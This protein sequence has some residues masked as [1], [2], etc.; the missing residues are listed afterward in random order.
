MDVLETVNSLGHASAIVGIIFGAGFSWKA[1]ML[2]LDIRNAI[3]EIRTEHG[4]RIARIEGH[5]GFKN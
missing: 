3:S 5:L 1:A 2:L 4:D